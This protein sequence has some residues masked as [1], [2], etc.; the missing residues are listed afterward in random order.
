MVDELAV[1]TGITTNVDVIPLFCDPDLLR[2]WKASTRSVSDRFGILF[3]GRLSKHKG[4]DILIRALK[5][6]RDQGLNANVTLV[7]N[8]APYDD[9]AQQINRLATSLNI[10]EHVSWLGNVN[11]TTLREAYQGADVL[12]LPSR[13]EGFGLPAIEAMWF[14]LPV[15]VSDAG[16]LPEVVGDGAL[17]FKT[18]DYG[19]LAEKLVILRENSEIRDRI[20][21]TARSVRELYTVEKF[22][23]SIREVWARYLS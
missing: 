21:H 3:V 14:D 22:N 4:L 17:I 2:N 18:N 16:A 15:I 8:Q 1:R 6:V 5:I 20:V 13:H 9:T 10:N 11:T 23:E 7:G 12:V 19:E